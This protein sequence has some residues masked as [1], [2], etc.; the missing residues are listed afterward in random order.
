MANKFNRKTFQHNYEVKFWERPG[1]FTCN[2]VESA[3]ARA[4]AVPTVLDFED[5]C[6]YAEEQEWI[7]LG[8]R[9]AVLG[10]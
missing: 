2:E 10:W 7:T 5:A 6:I 1:L 9:D 4:M 8:E 3:I